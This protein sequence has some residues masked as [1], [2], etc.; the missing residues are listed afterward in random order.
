MTVLS[1]PT[2]VEI[3]SD[4]PA[5]R[6][7]YIIHSWQSDNQPLE[8]DRQHTLIVH[9]NATATVIEIYDQTGEKDS[10]SQTTTHIELQEGAKINHFFIQNSASPGKQTATIDITQAKNSCYQSTIIQGG[11]AHLNTQYHIAL[12][13]AEAKCELKSLALARKQQHIDRQFRVSHNTPHTKSRLITRGL[14]NDQ[15]KSTFTGKIIVHPHASKT[16]ASLDDK[17]LVLSLQAEINTRPELEIY[18][19]DIICTHGATVG[20]LD[21][22]ALFYLASRGIPELT[23]KKLLVDAFM[24][25][26]IQDLPTSVLPYLEAMLYED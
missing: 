5:E 18:N 8:I 16:N 17:N 4:H 7:I 25:P 20:H 2:V 1:N 10:F 14:A 9:P 22:E 21:E 23:A 26:V 11:A 12:N 6:Y 13:G 24:Q 15:G 19:D 3:L